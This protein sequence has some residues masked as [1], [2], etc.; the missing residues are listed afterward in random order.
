MFPE[1]TP[2]CLA[3]KSFYFI[4]NVEKLLI[5]EVCWWIR[6]GLL[7]LNHGNLLCLFEV[8]RENLLLRCSFSRHGFLEVKSSLLG[9]KV[10]LFILLQ[11]SLWQHFSYQIVLFRDLN[12]FHKHFALVVD[13]YCGFCLGALFLWQK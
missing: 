11:S 12:F 13:S 7:L 9:S 5:L 1:W 8:F 4:K 6:H 3:C 2:E 10:F